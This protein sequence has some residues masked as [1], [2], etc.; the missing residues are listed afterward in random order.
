[1]AASKIEQIARNRFDGWRNRERFTQLK[2]DLLPVN[3]DEAYEAQA[4]LYA[5]MRHEAGFTEFAGHKVALTSPA[6]QEMCGVDHP[7]YG[8]IFHEF[9]Y[10]NRHEADPADFIRLGIEFEVGDQINGASFSQ[11]VLDELR[12]AAPE[13]ETSFSEAE[14]TAFYLASLP[15]T[16]IDPSYVPPAEFLH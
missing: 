15:A 12:A 16:G 8:A 9:V 11:A 10:Q 6:I 7:A 14:A 1:M 5:L 3:M 2:G 13:I 4:A